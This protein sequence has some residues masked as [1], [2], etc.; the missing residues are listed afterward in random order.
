MYLDLD[1]AYTLKTLM[2]VYN[3]FKNNALIRETEHGYHIYV[4]VECNFDNFI[5]CLVL[6]RTLGDDR[7]RIIMDIIRLGFFEFD[8][9][10]DVVFT[11][12]IKNENGLKH[13]IK[14]KWY[15]LEDYL[16]FRVV[17]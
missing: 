3:A 13:K 2:K 1:K 10:F 12:K 9:S 15:N 16:R 5:Y 4:P 11:E 17:I 7:N 8:N 6:R 14:G